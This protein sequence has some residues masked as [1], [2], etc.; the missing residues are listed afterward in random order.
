MPDCT[1]WCTL[2]MMTIVNS[3]PNGA[4]R[5]LKV[6]WVTGH[7]MHTTFCLIT[8]RKRTTWKIFISKWEVKIDLDL[9]EIRCKIGN[10]LNLLIRFVGERV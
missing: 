2:A 9:R 6:K 3:V 1:N 5:P 8:P 7:R 4:L 10:R